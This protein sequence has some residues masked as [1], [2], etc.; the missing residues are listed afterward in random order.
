M[1]APPWPPPAIGGAPGCAASSKS[2]ADVLSGSCRLEVSNIPDLGCCSTHR[3]EPALRLSQKELQLL[4]TPFKNALVGRFPFRRPP[5]EVIRGFFVSLGLKGDC[6]VGLLDLNHVL[7]RPSSEEDFTRLFV[8]RSW[9]VKGAQMLLSKWTLNFK[10]HQDSTYAPV[11][12][13]LPTC[14]DP[15]FP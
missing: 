3:G 5:M 7:I 6:D 15:I 14:D 8:C 13:S 2:F 4:S 10:V 1:E 12:V 9:F 11:W